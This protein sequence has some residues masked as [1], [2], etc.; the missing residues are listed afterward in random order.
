MPG[1]DAQLTGLRWARRDD[2]WRGA[3]LLLFFFL[4]VTVV[5]WNLASYILVHA[6]GF[7][8]WEFTS[9]QRGESEHQFLTL[10]LAS[11]PAA[12]LFFWI[13]RWRAG[14][15]PLRAAHWDGRRLT[16]TWQPRRGVDPARLGLRV[17]QAG[18]A[19]RLDVQLKEGLWEGSADL[20]EG[21]D[22]VTV[23]YAGRPVAQFLKR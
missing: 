16:L 8:S 15:V 13:P 14:P 5:C 22:A 17:A 23:L 19:P 9:G 7:Q 3:F 4:A 12:A 1:M 18:P 6:F 20:P 2:S 10:A 11:L 21:T